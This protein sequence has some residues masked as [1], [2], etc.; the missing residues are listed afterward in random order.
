[1]KN[2]LSNVINHVD[3]RDWISTFILDVEERTFDHR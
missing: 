2:E 3:A 1:M